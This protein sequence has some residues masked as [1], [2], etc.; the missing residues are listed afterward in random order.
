M[1]ST[2]AQ[3]RGTRLGAFRAR[4]RELPGGRL[5]WRIAVTVVG[6]AVIGIGIVLLPLP[7]PG[8]LVIFGGLGLLATEY[9][10]AA[11]LLRWM[12][13][14][15]TRSTRWAAE[16]PLWVRLGGGFVSLVLLIAVLGA[17]AWFVW[18]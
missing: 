14:Q 12:R 11:R 10:W 4:V 16:Q 1:T 2:D 18:R 7:G 6:V 15:V 9:A 3:R 8:W 5:G 13:W 17:A